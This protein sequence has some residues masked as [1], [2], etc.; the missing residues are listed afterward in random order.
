MRFVYVGSDE[1]KETV[2]RLGVKFVQHGKPFDVIDPDQVKQLTDDPDFVVHEGGPWEGGRVLDIAES[3][4]RSV[5]GFRSCTQ[6][7]RDSAVTHV[8]EQAGV[9]VD[10]EWDSARL[11]SELEA[12]DVT[13]G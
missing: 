1:S 9:K 6:D 8:L 10:S 5:S 2:T 13:N 7:E 3:D 4:F 12:L 11:Q